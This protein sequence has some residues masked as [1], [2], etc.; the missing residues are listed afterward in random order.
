MKQRKTAAAIGYTPEETA[1]RVLASGKG[2][3]AERIISL[4]VETGVPVVADPALAAMLESGVHPGD[5][6]PEWCWEATAKILAF[7]LAED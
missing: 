4:A 1:P 6:I 2:K 7:V 5:I 3:T